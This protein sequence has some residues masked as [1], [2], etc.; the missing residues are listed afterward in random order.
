MM[1]LF[2]EQPLAS[3]G[4]A[5]Y[6]GVFVHNDEMTSS[7]NEKYL[8]DFVTNQ[9]NAT[10]ARAYAILTEIRTLLSDIPLGTKRFEIGM[11]LR[12]H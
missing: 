3:P 9:A 5:K 1:R 10:K 12:D 2:V 4:S 7:I 11:A 6:A 8:E